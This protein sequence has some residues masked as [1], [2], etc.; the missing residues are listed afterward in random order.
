MDVWLSI[1]TCLPMFRMHGAFTF[2]MWPPTSVRLAVTRGSSQL[3]D[4]PV[5]S[6][7]SWKCGL[8]VTC[9]SDA[10]H[11]GPAASLEASQPSDILGT[12]L[13]EAHPSISH[14]SPDVLPIRFP[15]LCKWFCFRSAAASCPSLVQRHSCVRLPW[16]LPRLRTPNDTPPL[17]TVG[18]VWSTVVLTTVTIPAGAGAL[19]PRRQATAIA[20]SAGSW[21]AAF[22]STGSKGQGMVYARFA[23]SFSEN[24]RLA[25][26]LRR[27]P[28]TAYLRAPALQRHA[29]TQSD[30]WHKDPL[31]I[32]DPPRSPG[33]LEHMP[34]RRPRRGH[35]PQ[36]F[37]D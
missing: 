35:R 18:T 20:I 21:K 16:T 10:S 9:V 17:R 11:L 28:I 30:P 31:A 12:A 32:F 1:S 33:S 13:Q 26:R 6:R 19:S 15:V 29:S 3:Q 8:L 4:L 24:A 25:G 2:Y 37:P 34:Q 5:C 23:T 27:V 22:R 36:G 7:I 14:V